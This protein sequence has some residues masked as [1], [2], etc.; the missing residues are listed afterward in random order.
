MAARDVVP[1]AR[2]VLFDGVADPDRLERELLTWAHDA[3]PATGR[4]VEV[5]TRYDGEDL[6][7]VARLWDMTTAEVVGTHAGLEHEVAF[8]GFAPGSPTARVCPTGCGCR[9]GTTRGPGS[10]P[11]RWRWRTSGPASTRLRRRRGW[12]LLGRTEVQ[13]W[14]PARDEP[15]TLSPGTRVRFV[16][17]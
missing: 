10:R 8:C 15:A 7:E 6:G 17:T 16:A 4:L 13:L 14:D 11:A 1:A 2:S 9:A 12:Q 5:P 3:E